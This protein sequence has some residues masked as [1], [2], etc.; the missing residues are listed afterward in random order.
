[1][2][3]ACHSAFK[4]TRLPLLGAVTTA[5]AAH[6]GHR[7]LHLGEPHLIHLS[8]FPGS[9]KLGLHICVPSQRSKLSQNNTCFFSLGFI[10]T[11]FDGKAVL[12]A[13]LC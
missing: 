12:S 13:Q 7:V 11:I 8:S 10:C 3:G 5:G 4:L 9:R 6:R 2:I 1:M